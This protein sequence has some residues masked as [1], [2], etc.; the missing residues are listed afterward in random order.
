LVAFAGV[1]TLRRRAFM[2][3]YISWLQYSLLLN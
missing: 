3:G 1:A 2:F